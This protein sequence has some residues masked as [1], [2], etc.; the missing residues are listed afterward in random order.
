MFRN[1]VLLY[2]KALSAIVGILEPVNSQENRK[3]NMFVIALIK[4]NDN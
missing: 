4:K 2:L 3:C 1:N